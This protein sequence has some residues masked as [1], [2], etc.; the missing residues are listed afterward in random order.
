MLT[1]SYLR[2]GHDHDYGTTE[3]NLD[4][5]IFGRLDPSV[6]QLFPEFA[7]THHPRPVS[8]KTAAPSRQPLA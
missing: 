7:D 8:R 1:V 3:Y 2:R 6:Q 4:G 5:E